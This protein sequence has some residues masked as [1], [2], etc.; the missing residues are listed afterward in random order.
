[1]L[2]INRTSRSQRLYR[3]FIEKQRYTLHP[4]ASPKFTLKKGV[5][6]IA[7]LLISPSVTYGVME[8]SKSPVER[9]GQ[10]IERK[11]EAGECSV[12]IGSKPLDLKDAT[13]KNNGFY[14]EEYLGTT[15]F[16]ANAQITLRK[17]KNPIKSI[18]LSKLIKNSPIPELELQIHTLPKEMSKVKNEILCLARLNEALQNFQEGEFEDAMESFSFQVP[19]IQDSKENI[20]EIT[21]SL[22]NHIYR[23][24]NRIKTLTGGHEY[25]M[26]ISSI[27]GKT[28]HHYART[29]F[30]NDINN[31]K[32]DVGGRNFAQ[33]IK[34][35]TS[36][37]CSKAF[38]NL[39]GNVLST[40]IWIDN[41]IGT[42]KNLT[43]ITRY[44]CKETVKPHIQKSAA[45]LL[46]NNSN[47]L[48]KD[49]LN[50]AA[51][52]D[53]ASNQYQ[54]NITASREFHLKKHPR[55]VLE[56]DGW[57]PN[58]SQAIW[59]QSTG[60]TPDLFPLNTFPITEYTSPSLVAH[61]LK[62]NKAFN[63]VR[64]TLLE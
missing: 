49:N 15:Q 52:N 55:F 19:N 34:E 31:K 16:T 18:V 48:N 20:K 64:D 22:K 41:G 5:G 37:I 51:Y 4:Q 12:K 35:A 62:E 8:I 33:K 38:Q 21:N 42:S 1:M 61:T 13:V 53:L 11:A 7:A 50:L 57:T 17:D 45:A 9:I 46:V 25:G 40:S 6:L 44:N 58:P 26:E 63:N 23:I 28:M 3:G 39:A 43:N 30:T 24:S 10:Q 54:R 56:F 59:L 27:D 47:K 32:I 14:S 2:G 36:K 29:R 60:Y